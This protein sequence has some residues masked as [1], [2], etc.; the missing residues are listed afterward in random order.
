MKKKLSLL[1]SLFLLTQVYSQQP[2]NLRCDLVEHTGR[3]FINGKITQLTPDETG[4]IIEQVQLAT[5]NSKHPEFSWGIDDNRHNIKQTAFRVQLSITGSF[6]DST[7]IWDSGKVIS[8]VSRIKYQGE[9]LKPNTNY[10]WRVRIWNNLSE[11][12]RWSE[13]KI[14][15]TGTEMTD[16]SSA[17]YPLQQWNEI[18]VLSK[19]VN[20][21]THFIDFGKDSFG[22]II[23]T[24][25][26]KKRN[27][28][29]TISIGEV[30]TPSGLLDSLP[31]GS[32]RYRKIK[33]PLLQGIHTYVVAI[34][35]DERNT[36]STAVK[37]PSYI[38]DVLPFR[39]CEV[40]GKAKITNIYKQ[41][42]SYFFNDY[43]S[44]FECSD[45]ILN[46]IWDFCKY[47]IKATSFA[48]IYVDGDRERI[49]YEADA[50]INQLCQYGVDDEYTLARRSMEYLLFHPTWP[51]EWIMTSV[52]MAR[53][54]YRYTGNTDFIREYYDILKSKTLSALTDENGLISTRTG[55][56]TP[57]VNRSIRFNGKLRDIVDWPHSGMLGLSN[58]DSGETDGF[59][60]TDYNTVVNAYHYR[61]L[62]MMSKMASAIGKTDDANMYAQKA[63][64]FKKTFNKLL[65]DKKRGIYK[66]G[67]GTGHSSLHSNMFALTFGL[68]PEK[69]V[70][71][72]MDFIR[73][74][75]MACSVYGSQHLLD[76][77][78]KAED[79]SYGLRLL[80][81]RSDRGWAHA[82]YD[83]GTTITLEAWDNK[84]KPN[85]DW[86]HAWGA[87]PANIIPMKLM[88]IEPLKPGFE[89]I[90]V[91][92]QTDT[93]SRA[94][95]KYPSI[96]GDILLQ[97]KNTPGKS[98]TLNVTFPANTHNNEVWVLCKKGLK[99]KLTL[100]GKKTKAKRVRNFLVLEEL[101][102]GEYRVEVTL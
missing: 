18:P 10:Y 19:A 98:Y 35:K 83:V 22:R 23:L 25:D 14:F 3:V 102:S 71:T 7:K 42:V 4:E 44:D 55:K 88:G 5:I 27:D 50:Y 26:S 91:K 67:I 38:G 92:P 1:S 89:S 94:K 63:E 75:G 2:F 59:V 41:S 40:Q 52:L 100:N 70:K 21:D 73:S 65:L 60:F 79:A 74:R 49:S 77:V 96:K 39:Y 57:E 29:L 8:E 99:Y 86:N 16:Y 76:A 33:Q 93:L 95:I 80:T 24:A 51:T 78:Y 69:Y 62:L 56:L 101:G 90:R 46:A 11:K 61:A 64:E 13:T 20:T 47:S 81:S 72:V 48:G 58:D 97:I 31:G 45:T 12:S 68:V 15:R 85:Q 37:M 43:S 9:E 87:A 34:K 28:T 66:D 82:I 54:D 36:R 6:D 84:Y 32:R 17:H 53:E 30:I